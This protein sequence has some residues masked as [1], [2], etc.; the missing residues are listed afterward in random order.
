MTRDGSLQFV[1]GHRHGRTTDRRDDVAGLDPGEVSGAPA[2]YRRNQGPL[3][4]SVA[5]LGTQGCPAGIGDR[6]SSSVFD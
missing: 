3:P 2:L 1:Q 5:D 6:A 4:T